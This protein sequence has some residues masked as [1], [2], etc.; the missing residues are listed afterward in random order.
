V[1]E[2]DMSENVVGYL[3]RAGR[4]ARNGLRGEGTQSNI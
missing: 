3:N 2:Y 4:T 1:I